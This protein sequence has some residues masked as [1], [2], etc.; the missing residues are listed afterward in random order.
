LSSTWTT[1]RNQLSPRQRE[2][3]LWA[4]RG[5]TY[6]EIAQI[7]GLSYGSVKTYLDAARYKLNTVNLPQACAVAAADGV[8]TR[9]EILTG[10]PWDDG[11][12][13]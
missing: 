10:H 9:D 5:K 7:S 2:L 8:Y 12:V 4:C 6:T 3:L 11:D 13:E 1:R